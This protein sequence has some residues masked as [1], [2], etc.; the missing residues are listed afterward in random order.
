MTRLL[1]LTLALAACASPAP[2]F[3]GAKRTEV[4][5]D[6]RT[7]VVFQKGDRVSVI[8]TGYAPRRDLQKIRATMIQVIPQATGCTLR[9]WSLKG[10]AGEMR[11][12]LDCPD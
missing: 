5:V 3:M 9:E 1:L 4:T 12:S 7:Y 10:D 6:G 2:E 11:G 8:R